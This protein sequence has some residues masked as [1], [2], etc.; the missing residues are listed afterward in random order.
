MNERQLRYLQVIIEEALHA[1][2]TSSD[3][4]LRKEMLI[5]PCRH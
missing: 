3:S 1:R 2:F 4:M 5:N